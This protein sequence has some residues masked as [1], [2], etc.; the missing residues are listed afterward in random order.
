MLLANVLRTLSDEELERVRKEFSLG[1][2]SRLI[3]ERV[4]AAASSPPD[5][6]SLAKALKLSKENF[7][8]VCS[9][10]VDECVRI[11]APKEEFSALRFFLSKYLY[12][13]FAGELRRV[14]KKLIAERDRATLER[15]Y[16]FVFIEGMSFPV[17]AVD[18]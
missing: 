12:R 2:R 4:A 16:E 10:I 17:S 7:Y 1:E 9:E 14:E 18:L 5:A 3:F 6:E 8:R 13:P 15:F 11:L